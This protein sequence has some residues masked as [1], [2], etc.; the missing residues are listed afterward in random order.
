MTLPRSEEPTMSGLFDRMPWGSEFAEPT[1]PDHIQPEE[2]LGRQERDQR[3]GQSQVLSSPGNHESLAQRL[4]SLPDHVVEMLDTGSV[5]DDE[6]IDLG[7]AK[8]P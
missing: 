1:D 2:S 6:V 8:I 5:G 4:E 3:S 7:R